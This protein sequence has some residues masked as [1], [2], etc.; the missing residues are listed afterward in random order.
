MSRRNISALIIVR[1]LLAASTVA[2]QRVPPAPP[3]SNPHHELITE[4]LSHGATFKFK[5]APDLPEFTF[6]VIPEPQ[7][8]DE[9]GNLHT[10]VREVQLSLGDSKQPVQS[11]EGCEFSDMEAPPLDSDWFRTVDMNFD[12]YKDIYILTNWGATGNE[13]GC[14]WLYNRESARFE[15]SKEFSELGRFTLDPATKTI[16]TY[17][18][19]G[20]AGTVFRAVKYVIEDNLPA[21]VITVAQDWDFKKSEYHCVVQQRRG[22]G[23]ALVTVR[24]V[25]AESKDDFHAPCDPSHPFRGIG[26]K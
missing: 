2:A 19:G 26:D 16:T 21:P 1:T 13:S 24:D 11:L 8:A 15:Y 3:T 23:N 5:I 17:G 10:V 7:G 25:W 6:N 12:G 9:Y 14:V 4:D 22:R 18:N 20:R